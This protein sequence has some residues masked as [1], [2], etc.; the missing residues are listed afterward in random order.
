MSLVKHLLFSEEEFVHN[1][2]LNGTSVKGSYNTMQFVLRLRDD[3]RTALESDLDFER[4][5]ATS[6]S[7]H[8]NIHWWQHMGSNFGF[9]FSLAYPALVHKTS[10]NLKAIISQGILLKSI[11]KFDKEYFKVNGVADIEDINEILNNFHDLEY[12]KS[13]AMD[14]KNILTMHNDRRFFL[15]IGHCYHILW[16]LTID[17]L[18]STVDKEHVCL[19]NTDNWVEKFKV[20][21]DKK[22]PGFFVDSPLHLLSPLG[23]KA[24]YEGQAIFNQIQYL[25]VA[26]NKELSFSDCENAGML[27]SIYIEAFDHY[28]QITKFDKPD[29]LLDPTIGLFLLLCDVAINPN[30]GFPLEIYDFENFITKNDPAIRFT[31]MCRVIAKD[32]KSYR[33]RLVN[34]SKEEYIIL[35]KKLSEAIACKCSYENIDMVL[36]WIETKSV[37][38]VIKE[39]EDLNFSEENQPIRLM[40]SRYYRFQE[41]KKKYPNVLC[42]FGYHSTSANKNIEFKIVDSL[43]KKHHALFVDDFDGEVKPTIFEGVNKENIVESF[44]KFYGFNIIYDI[45]LKWIYEEGEFKY[46]Y[47]WLAGDRS[48]TFIPVIKQNF[49]NQF[50]IDIGSI[51][52]L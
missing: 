35:S 20:L 26:L 37:F 41:D 1:S 47:D 36:R 33:D 21:E 38:E 31:M 52:V 19:P 45:I 11:L 40:F 50:G 8:E 43:Y 24:I 49:K 15:N 51:K 9:L 22:V 12:A 32:P 27:H 28:L 16:G 5:N 2:I 7:I 25:R 18:A 48:K 17:L 13:F 34:Y 44:D 46:D 42:W 29:D 39:G 3:I 14:N 10:V 6:T 23:I 4:I 30:N